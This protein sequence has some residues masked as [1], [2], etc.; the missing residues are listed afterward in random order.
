MSVY[1]PQSPL[2]KNNSGK[3]VPKF[4]LRPARK[5]GG[6]VELLSPNAKPFTLG[7][8]IEELYNK[9]ATFNETDF[10]ICIGNP[11]ILATTVAVASDV[12]DGKVNM[13]QWHGRRKE[14][15][16]V[17]MDLGFTSDPD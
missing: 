9:L 14:Y 5:H 13:L 2:F 12:A 10:I 15:I 3:L 4:D 17:E 6:I 16:P 8:L 7:P 1:V 11:I